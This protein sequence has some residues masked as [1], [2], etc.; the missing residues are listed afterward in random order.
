MQVRVGGADAAATGSPARE[1][2]DEAARATRRGA[3]G[4]EVAANGGG[5]PVGGAMTTGAPSCRRAW[6]LSSF[7]LAFTALWMARGAKARRH[8]TCTT[9]ACTTRSNHLLCA[10]RIT[11]KNHGASCAALFSLG[12]HPPPPHPQPFFVATRHS[13]PRRQ[14]RVAAKPPIQPPQKRASLSS[15][16]GQGWLTSIWA[17]PCCNVRSRPRFV[18]VCANRRRRALYSFAIRRV[19]PRRYAHV[20]H[21]DIDLQS[22]MHATLCRVCTFALQFR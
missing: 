1:A 7:H 13:A 10:L 21:I 18:I 9:E 22:L 3:S 6:L 11:P 4:R 14:R 20:L 12:P 17:R 2:E 8:N 19:A 5:G 16:T 15:A